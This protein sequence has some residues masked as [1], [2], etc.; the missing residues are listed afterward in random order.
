[1]GRAA[2]SDL[3]HAEHI[4]VKGRDFIDIVGGQGDML[5]LRHA[6]SLG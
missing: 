3:F 5:D 6:L 4:F 2:P 1:V